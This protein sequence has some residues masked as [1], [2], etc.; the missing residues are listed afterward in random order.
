MPVEIKA[1]P[2][3]K[4]G[5]LALKCQHCGKVLY[6]DVMEF[7]QSVKQGVVL[8]CPHCKERSI[9]EIDR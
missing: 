9:F 3:N 2:T 6:V 5:Y 7:S 8:A 4:G 1:Y